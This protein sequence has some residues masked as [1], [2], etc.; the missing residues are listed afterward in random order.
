MKQWLI[1]FFIAII[2]VFVVWSIDMFPSGRHYEVGDL[3]SYPE[4]NQ[5]LDG[6]RFDGLINIYKTD[7]YGFTYYIIDGSISNV[8]ELRVIGFDSTIEGCDYN[9]DFIFNP[10]REVGISVSKPLV[11][12]FVR[13][14]RDDSPG[15]GNVWMIV[16]QNRNA[17]IRILVPR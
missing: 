6:I 1:L 10:L 8:C 12:P 17:L 13:Y 9:Y 4:L 5:L 11:G 2:S 15:K 14:Y 3:T 7:R 16:D